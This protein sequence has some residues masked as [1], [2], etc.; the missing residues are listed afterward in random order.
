[1]YERIRTVLYTHLWINIPRCNYTVTG[2]LNQNA[3]IVV[4]SPFMSHLSLN[5]IRVENFPSN[6]TVPARYL[7][8]NPAPPLRASAT[9]TG[10][11]PLRSLYF[12]LHTEL[13]TISSISLIRRRLLVLQYSPKRNIGEMSLAIRQVD[14]TAAFLHAPIGRNPPN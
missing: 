10:H 13:T 1:M 3:L 6:P 2:P 5:P 12:L 14:C 8:P 4:V 11:Q 9:A 7:L